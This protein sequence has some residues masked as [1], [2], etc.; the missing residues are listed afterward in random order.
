[1]WLILLGVLGLTYWECREQEYERKL[2][3]WWLS[4]VFLLHFPAYIGMRMWVAIQNRKE[5]T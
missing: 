5:Q 1:M 2:T 4:F 3:L